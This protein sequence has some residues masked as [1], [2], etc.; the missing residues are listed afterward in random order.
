MTEPWTVP[1]W[2]E[3]IAASDR[4][5]GVYHIKSPDR[6]NGYY[7]LATTGF[8]I[9]LV[10]LPTE[11]IT[12]FPEFAQAAAVSGW[13]TKAQPVGIV[14]PAALRE[15]VGSWEPPQ[16]RKCDVCEDTGRVNRECDVCGDDHDC[17]CEE[18]DGTTQI[19]TKPKVRFGRV[20]GVLVDQNQMALLTPGMVGETCEVRK[21]VDGNMTVALVFVGEGWITAV[22]CLRDD[23]NNDG[24]AFPLRVE[25]GRAYE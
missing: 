16:T 7:A 3:R 22:A 6:Y 20:F 23:R 2:M 15:Y 25:D 17:K 11:E 13:V 21:M 9:A 18:C 14:H 10:K 4:F 19:T 8:V 24:P 12:R 1:P 5:K